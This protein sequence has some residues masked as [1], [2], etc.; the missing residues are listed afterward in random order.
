MHDLVLIND[1][2]RPHVPYS[3]GKISLHA[4]LF[5]KGWDV[6]LIQPNKITTLGPNP[7]RFFGVGSWSLDFWS[8][9]KTASF[10]KKRYPHIPIICGGG[11]V[12]ACPSD[13]QKHADI[14]DYWVLGEGEVSLDEIL[15]GKHQRHTF[16]RRPIQAT[17]LTLPLSAHNKVIHSLHLSM[18]SRGCINKCSFC[19]THS[20]FGNTIRHIPVPQYIEHIKSLLTQGMTTLSFMDSSFFNDPRWATDFCNAVINEQLQFNWMAF[21]CAE[22]LTEDRITLMKKAG[23]IVLK[24]GVESGS[25]LLLTTMNKKHQLPETIRSLNLCKQY[26]I[27]IHIFL[28]YGLLDEDRE[29]MVAT[30]EFY[31]LIKP[32]SFDLSRYQ[33]FPGT[34]MFDLAKRRGILSAYD[35]STGDFPQLTHTGGMTIDELHQEYSRLWGGAQYHRS[36]IPNLK[37]FALIFVPVVLIQA[38]L[39]KLLHLKILI[40]ILSLE[41]WPASFRKKLQNKRFF[42]I[43]RIHI[44]QATMLQHLSYHNRS[45]SPEEMS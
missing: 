5:K 7:A 36:I 30:R 24:I 10:L 2:F 11:H 4:Y 28:M 3:Y 32:D 35:W 15:Q 14:F 12:T 37:R 45:L 44:Y 20:M 29:S 33:P 13:L 27:H 22:Q 9:V 38:V 42:L 16:I 39:L 19:G 1:F 17:D 25:A 43:G 23:C 8:V 26:G 31:N 41:A 40:C 18:A 6:A 21:V 34:A